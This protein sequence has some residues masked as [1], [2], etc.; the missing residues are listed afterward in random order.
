VAPPG[1]PLAATPVPEARP[2]APDEAPLGRSVTDMWALLQ[3]GKPVVEEV[4]CF[5]WFLMRVLDISAIIRVQ[6]C[7]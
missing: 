3:S 2:L 6:R 5:G 7:R 1:G 4:R